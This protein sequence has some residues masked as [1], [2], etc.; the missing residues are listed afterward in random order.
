MKINS[1]ALSESINK[2]LRPIY[3]LFAEESFQL[4]ELSDE[5]INKARNH[6][7]NEKLSY[8]IT[9]DSDWSFLDTDNENLDLFG[10]KKIIEV[11]LLGAGQG[12][13]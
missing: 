5:I 3:V 9:K 8:V 12:H 4:S 2:E 10:S 13:N 11:K 7:Y 6:D 1:Q